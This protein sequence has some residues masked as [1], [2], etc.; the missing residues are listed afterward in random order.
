[1]SWMIP[2][3]GTPERIEVFD[4]VIGG[5]VVGSGRVAYVG[6]SPTNPRAVV[7]LDLARGERR[8]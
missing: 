2:V 1:M 4:T 8:V 5:L 6:G 3:D 7:L